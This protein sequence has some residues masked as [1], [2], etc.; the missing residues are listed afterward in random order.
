[1]EIKKKILRKKI[2]RQTDGR[3]DRSGV[4]FRKASLANYG[5]KFCRY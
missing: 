1:M 2:D 5:R 4:R 3:I